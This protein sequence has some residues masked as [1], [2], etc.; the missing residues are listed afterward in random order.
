MMLV[1]IRFL[2]ETA[3][4]SFTDSD[5]SGMISNWTLEGFKRSILM[6]VEFFFLSFLLSLGILN[7]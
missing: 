6:L 7:G 2:G 4:L 1:S 5:C 3:K